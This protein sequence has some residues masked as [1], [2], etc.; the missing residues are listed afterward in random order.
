M[1]E[2]IAAVFANQRELDSEAISVV[3]EVIDKLERGELRVAE[4][5]DGQWITHSWIKQAVLLYFRVESMREIVAGE[6][7]FYDKIP[8]RKW[9][10]R[11][12]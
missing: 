3:R 1:Q 4:K 8:L 10:K 5:V 7:S 6:L 12:E 2:M 11:R 9:E